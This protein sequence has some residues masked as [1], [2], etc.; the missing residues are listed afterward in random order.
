[1]KSVAGEM[2]TRTCTFTRRGTDMVTLSLAV[3]VTVTPHGLTGSGG[4][5][6]G[7]V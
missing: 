5:G 2:L 4:V 6:G 1:M 3:A 7:A